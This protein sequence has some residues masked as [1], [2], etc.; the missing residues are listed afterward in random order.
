[1]QTRIA[2]GDLPR[3]QQ[4]C[5]ADAVRCRGLVARKV[6]WVGMHFSETHGGG[7]YMATAVASLARR[8]LVQI[9]AAGGAASPTD[10]G[11]AVIDGV[12]VMREVAA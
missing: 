7:V 11:I 9:S 12:A 10:A 2:L 3:D 6:G 4:L 5:L 1:M 8:G